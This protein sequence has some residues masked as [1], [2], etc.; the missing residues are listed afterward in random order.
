MTAGS[1]ANLLLTREARRGESSIEISRSKSDRTCTSMSPKNVPVSTRLLRSGFA[2]PRIPPPSRHAAVEDARCV[3][4]PAARLPRSRAG[5]DRIPARAGDDTRHM[6]ATWARG[7][8][9]RPPRCQQ[10]RS[11][12]SPLE[13]RLRCWAR[14]SPRHARWPPNARPEPA[15]AILIPCLDEEDGVAL[16]VKE[17]AAAF[18]A[19]GSWSSTTGPPIAPRSAR[20]RRAPRWSRSPGAARPGPSSPR[21]ACSRKT[22]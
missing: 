19:R 11:G 7:F 12:R 8:S 14:I 9:V 22:S 16:V 17:Y 1:L 2:H 15:V 10:L 21:S 20:A 13:S 4:M 6:R 18:P 3:S 5:S